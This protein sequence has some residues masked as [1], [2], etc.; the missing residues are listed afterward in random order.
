M[1]SGEIL[2][3]I[4]VSNGT[5]IDRSFSRLGGVLR[6]RLAWAV[7]KHARIFV[8][9]LLSVLDRRVSTVYLVLDSGKGLFINLV[10]LVPILRAFNKKIVLHVHVYGF[11]NK[12]SAVMRCLVG[13]LSKSDVRYIMLCRCMLEVFEDIYDAKGRCF[14]LNNSSFAGSRMSSQKFSSL[15]RASGTIRVGMIGN[16]TIEKGVREFISLARSEGLQ[17]LEYIMAGPIADASVRSEV[18]L[19]CSESP[20]SRRYIGPVYGEEK[21]KFFESID[22]LAFPTRYENEAQPLT[23]YE[24]LSF[25]VPVVSMNRGCI[26][27]QVP[28]EWCFN[29]SEWMVGSKDLL[30]SWRD[31]A[32]EYRNAASKASSVFRDHLNYSRT[33]LQELLD[34]AGQVSA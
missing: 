2:E 24:A 29:E 17:G 3:E 12:Y 19:F 4:R 18:E 21:N 26:S 32:N 16:L 6:N 31:E 34:W 27:E 10:L 22:V 25:G 5:V 9:L 8:S 13:A 1:V 14:V 28:R 15:E 11:I 23:I 20:E 33:Q 30:L 7:Y